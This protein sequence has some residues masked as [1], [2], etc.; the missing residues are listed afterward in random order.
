SL[1][2][3]PSP[4]LFLYLGQS[5]RAEETAQRQGFVTRRAVHLGPEGGGRLVVLEPPEIGATPRETS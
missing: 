2:T 5:S 3:S 4:L 1:L